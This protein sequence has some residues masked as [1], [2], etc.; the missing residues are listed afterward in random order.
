L[1]TDCFKKSSIASKGIED[2]FMLSN[3]QN[4]NFNLA[5]LI[6]LNSEFMVLYM[7]E[8]L[9]CGHDEILF[10]IKQRLTFQPLYGSD[11]AIYG[12][13]P[14]FLLSTLMKLLME[15]CVLLVWPQKSGFWTSFEYF[16]LFWSEGGFENVGIALGLS[17]KYLLDFS[18]P[19]VHVPLSPFLT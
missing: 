5:D 4:G 14:I 15:L 6:N 7:D 13:T 11:Q 2:L 17:T 8:Y 1:E 9:A 19:N 12:Y 18:S 3:Y 16:A 10:N